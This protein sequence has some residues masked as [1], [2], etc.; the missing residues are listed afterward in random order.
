MVDHRFRQVDDGADGE[1]LGTEKTRHANILVTGKSKAGA[2]AGLLAIGATIVQHPAGGQ[3]MSQNHYKS[4][5]NA[6]AAG[7]A[8]GA[9]LIRPTLVW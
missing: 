4:T 8:D 2:G 1:R 9:I 5:K 3:K 7:A 6:H